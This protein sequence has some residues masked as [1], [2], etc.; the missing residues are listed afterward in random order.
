MEMRCDNEYIFTSFDNL[1]TFSIATEIE[2]VELK[3]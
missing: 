2:L 1:H 3:R